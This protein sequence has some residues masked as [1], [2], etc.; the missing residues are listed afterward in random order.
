MFC[1]GSF[2]KSRNAFAVACPSGSSPAWRCMRSSP[3]FVPRIL[4][5]S[6]SRR[7]AMRTCECEAMPRSRYAVSSRSSLPA[8]PS[9]AFMVRAMSARLSVSRISRPIIL[10]QVSVTAE[11]C[12]RSKSRCRRIPR[13]TVARRP[14]SVLRAASRYSTLSLLRLHMSTMRSKMRR[15]RVSSAVAG[16]GAASWSPSRKRYSIF[17][18]S[19]TCRSDS[20]VVPLRPLKGASFTV[21]ESESPLR[22]SRSFPFSIWVSRWS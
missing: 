10:L 14:V 4:E 6:S 9:I 13:A 18:E 16:S 19:E 7:R 12:A 21:S 8:L 15:E 11:S 22:L 3:V 2:R 20:K 5:R 1:S 17:F